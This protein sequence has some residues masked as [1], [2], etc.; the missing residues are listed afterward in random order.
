MNKNKIEQIYEEKKEKAYDKLHYRILNLTLDFQ[1]FAVNEYYKED[2][3]YH[4][5]QVEKNLLDCLKTMD[6]NCLSKNTQW[7]ADYIFDN[8]ALDIFEFHIQDQ[9]KQSKLID[10][11]RD[12]Q[13][14][15][16]QFFNDFSEVI[17]EQEYESED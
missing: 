14:D 4:V 17:Q 12:L 1:N 2:F 11:L 13:H 16:H 6:E 7:S 15:L 3:D 8:D 10:K 9:I 5:L